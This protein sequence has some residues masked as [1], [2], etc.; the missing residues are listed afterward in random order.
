MKQFSIY[1]LSI[2]CF[3][4]SCGENSS[5][6]EEKNANTV[7]NAAPQQMAKAGEV[8]FAQNCKM[9]HGINSMEASD[10]APVLDS[11]KTHWP[12]KAILASYIKNAK[13][14]LNSNEYTTQLYEKWKSKPQM[15]PYL[16]MTDL[17]IQQIVEYLHTASN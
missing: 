17:E 16:G 10:M 5:K 11:V 12:D 8:L 4:I 2:A 6:P 7:S 1:I 9:C 15:P 14:M 3:F 13:E